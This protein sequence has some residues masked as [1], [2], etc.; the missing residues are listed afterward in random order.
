MATDCKRNQRDRGAASAGLRSGSAGRLVPPFPPE[1]P[2]RPRGLAAW[3]L[4]HRTTQ[5]G[6]PATGTTAADATT[7]PESMA[8]IESTVHRPPGVLSASA[9]RAVPGG[10]RAALRRRGGCGFR[11]SV[12][13]MS[14]FARCPAHCVRGRGRARRAAADPRV[15]IRLGEV[16]ERDGGLRDDGEARRLRGLS[17]DGRDDAARPQILSREHDA[18][19][20]SAAGARR[21]HDE[22]QRQDG[23]GTQARRG[24]TRLPHIGGCWAHRDLLQTIGHCIAVLVIAWRGTTGESAQ[25]CHTRPPTASRALSRRSAGRYR[26]LAA[27][28]KRN[29]AQIAQEESA[30]QPPTGAG[31]PAVRVRGRSG[32]IWLVPP[33]ARGRDALEILGGTPLRPSVAD[34]LQGPVSVSVQSGSQ[35]RS[36]CWPNAPPTSPSRPLDRSCGV[37]GGCRLPI[38]GSVLC[39]DRSGINPAGRVAPRCK[40]SMEAGGSGW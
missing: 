23:A 33:Q 27:G 11:A 18:L 2:G 35:R 24:A 20:R 38:V 3:A 31:S 37:R 16:D 39:W 1:A 22:K 19:C 12:A 8:R 25:A 32:A 26:A 15:R 13:G 5:A 40:R 34:A 28:R 21:H 36:L 17:G 30:I 14:G 29:R 4:E 7:G 6:D 9:S 10:A